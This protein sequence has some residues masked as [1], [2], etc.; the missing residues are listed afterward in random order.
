MLP[1]PAAVVIRVL[2]LHK[3]METLPPDRMGHLALSKT[4]KEDYRLDGKE[5]KITWGE[6]IM[7]ITIPDQPA[8]LDPLRLVLQRRSE[9]SEM[10]I[11]RWNVNDIR[12]E[13]FLKTE[14]VLI[15]LTYNSSNSKL[16]EMRQTLP[17]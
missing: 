11:R 10:Q 16:L 1:P 12:T 8:G 7:W 2:L 15:R 14:P 13:P 9:M 4:H 3:R 6:H 5:E 17:Q